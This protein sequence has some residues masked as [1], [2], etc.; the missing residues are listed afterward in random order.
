MTGKTTLKRVREA[1]IEQFREDFPDEKIYT[2]VF[3][4]YLLDRYS[5]LLFKIHQRAEEVKQGRET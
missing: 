5:R 4:L 2:K 1:I 3:S